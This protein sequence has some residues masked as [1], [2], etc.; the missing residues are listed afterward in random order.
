MPKGKLAPSRQVS[1]R[2]DP[3]LAKRI[4][5][6]AAFEEL[7]VADFA[8]KLFRRAFAEYQ[9]AGSLHALRAK[10]GDTPAPKRKAG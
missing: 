1:F 10:D 2:I 3:E 6:A 8:R 4:E 5:D 7:S 9:T